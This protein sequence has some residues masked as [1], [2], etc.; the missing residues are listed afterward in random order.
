MRRH[1]YLG[2][3]GHQI[4]RN[5]V[6]EN[7]LAGDGAFFKVVESSRVILEI[8]DERTRFRTFKQ[9]LRFTF[10]NPAAFHTKIHNVTK[11]QNRSIPKIVEPNCIASGML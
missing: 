5:A 9:D 11:F 1:A 2:E 3:L 4:F 8:L 6:V 10:V 7:T